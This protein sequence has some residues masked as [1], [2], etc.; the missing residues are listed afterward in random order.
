MRTADVRR[1]PS[2]ELPP[3]RPLR[4]VG[5]SV[6]ELPGATAY[7]PRVGGGSG[8]V[9]H[10]RG[11]ESV[12]SPRE[13]V[14]IELRCWARRSA[15]WPRRWARRSRSAFSA[16]I[17]ERRDCSTAIFDERGRMIRAG[18]ASPS[19]SARCRT[20][21]PPSPRTSR[22]RGEVWILNDPFA[23][24]THLPDLTMVS[25][26]AMASRCRRAHHADVGALEPGSMPAESRTLAEEGVVIPPTRLDDAR[27]SMRS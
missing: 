22:P 18:R 21:S 2:V 4:V 3:A 1:G 14:P 9:Y 16:N 8:W 20:P 5:P 13:I 27:R 17:K 12:T 6:L 10:A 24:G 23:G 15:P 26:T 11:D 19:T 25:R 7:V